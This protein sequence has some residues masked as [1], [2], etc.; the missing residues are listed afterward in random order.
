M[1]QEFSVS[2]CVYGGDDPAFFDTAF[3]SIVDQTSQPNEIVLTVDGPIPSS[4]ESVIE[5]YRIQLS[6]TDIQFHVIY[7]ETNKGHGEARRICFD[8]CSY[9]LIALMDADDYFANRAVYRPFT[10]WDEA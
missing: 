9:D 10:W 8:H 6:Q 4:I 5:K 1:N 3:G 7:L 2:M